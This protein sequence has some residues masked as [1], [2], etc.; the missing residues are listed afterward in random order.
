M[1]VT[2]ASMSGLTVLDSAA[3]LYYLRVGHRLYRLSISLGH[4]LALQFRGFIHRGRGY[5]SHDIHHC[6]VSSVLL[7]CNA[8]RFET[9]YRS[10]HTNFVHTPHILLV[11]YRDLEVFRSISSHLSHKQTCICIYLPPS[12]TSPLLSR[13]WIASHDRAHDRE[14]CECISACTGIRL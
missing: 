1:S 14:G 2:P 13:L 10:Y 11:R 5:P 4:V 9:F 12:I 8:G 7:S 6:C 3:T